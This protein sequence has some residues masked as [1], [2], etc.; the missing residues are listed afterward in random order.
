LEQENNLPLQIAGSAGSE[1][2][3]IQL[4]AVM[5]PCFLSIPILTCPQTAL[6]SGK[7]S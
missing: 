7:V 4:I 2:G 1:N 3:W 6:G 5:Q